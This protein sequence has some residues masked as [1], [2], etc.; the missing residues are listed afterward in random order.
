MHWDQ[1]ENLGWACSVCGH[2]LP[3]DGSDMSSSPWQ[4][5]SNCAVI[6]DNEQTIDALRQAIFL[7]NTLILRKHHGKG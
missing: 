6:V 1:Q 3:A 5:C 7:L 4:G 2:F